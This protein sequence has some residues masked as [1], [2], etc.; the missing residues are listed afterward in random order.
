MKRLLLA[1][2]R[3]QVARIL[4]IEITYTEPNQ[5]LERYVNLIE[6]KKEKSLKT[7]PALRTQPPFLPYPV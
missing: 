3:R 2:V 4:N 7:P 6:L 1:K 5:I